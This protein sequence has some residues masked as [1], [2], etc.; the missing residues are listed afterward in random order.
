M[1]DNIADSGR[2]ATIGVGAAARTWT[3]GDLAVVARFLISTCLS[4]GVVVGAGILKVPQILRV[5][6]S[7]SSEGVSLLS[8]YIEL[9]SYVIS[10]GWGVSQSLD[11][12]DYGENIFIFVQLLVLVMLVARMQ[13]TARN[14]TGILVAQLASFQ[15]FASGFVPRHI[16]EALLSGLIL[17]NIASR[18]PQIRLNYSRQSTGQLSFLTVFLAFGGG[19]ARVMTTALNVP[20]EKGKLVMLFQFG[21]AALLNTILIGQ[22]LYYRS[23]ESKGDKKK[24]GGRKDKAE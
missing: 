10:T 5:W 22:I 17:L 11:F 14:A 13:G 7:G 24:R 6:K 23:K 2:A 15:V 20:W 1:S 19:I 18:V 9:F 12:R 21:V 3:V 8:L 16:H 4:Y